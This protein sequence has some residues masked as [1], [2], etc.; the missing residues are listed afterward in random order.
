MRSNARF[1]I[2]G[3]AVFLMAVGSLHAAIRDVP[4]SFS[5][6]QGAINASSSGDVVQVAAGLY[7]EN[8]VLK[9]GVE[10]IGAGP[11]FT[12]IDGGETFAT[13]WIPSGAMRDTRVEGFTIRNGN[14]DTG[15]GVRIEGGA[16]PTIT[17]C[18][19]SGNYAGVRGGGIYADHSAQPLIEFCT[20]KD[21]WSREGAGIYSQNGNPEIRW[22]VICHNTA[23]TM[24]G[25]IHIAFSMGA[26]VVHNT[27]A[28][29]RLEDGMDYGSGLCISSSMVTVMSNI[30]AFNTGGEGF[31][32]YGSMIDSDCNLVHGN[33]IGDI[34]GSCCP[35]E[36]GPYS[37]DADPLFCDTASCDLTVAGSSPAILNEECGLIGAQTVGCDFTPTKNTSWG[38]VKKMYR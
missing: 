7:E 19:I 35:A 38:E 16:A 2:I 36:P 5:T 28:L 13:L 32:V 18:V 22:N 3:L 33:D 34:Y 29:N 8:V 23:K 14:S 25:G 20:I 6:I 21:N 30:I 24:G 12:I 1:L 11:E 4:A 31:W 10:L 26:S 17:N 9:P 27:I 15:G 37:F